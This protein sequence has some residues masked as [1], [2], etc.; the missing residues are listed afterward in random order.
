ML[1]IIFHPKREERSGGWRKL[2][3]EE[4]HNVYPSPSIIRMIKLRSIKCIGPVRHKY[5]ILVRKSEEKRS[6]G[7]LG[8]R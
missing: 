1:T 7:R 5:K 6:L 3:D 2:H 8:Y 4:L